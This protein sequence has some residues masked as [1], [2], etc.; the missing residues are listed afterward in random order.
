[1]RPPG[2]EPMSLDFGGAVSDDEDDDEGG[3]H[4]RSAG[5][6]SKY[7][8]DG[9]GGSAGFALR[10]AGDAAGSRSSTPTASPPLRAPSSPDSHRPIA[11]FD[12]A[13]ESLGLL[14]RGSFS[15]VFRARSRRS[16]R[17]Y[18]VKRS[19][20]HV[21]SAAMRDRLAREVALAHHAGPHPAVL[22]Y[23]DAWQ[24]GGH[25][26]IRT[27]CC[28]NGTLASAAARA[29]RGVLPGAQCTSDSPTGPGPAG[30]PGA[31]CSASSASSSGAAAGAPPMLRRVDSAF[32]THVPRAVLPEAALWAVAAR[33]AGGLAHLHR[34][35]VIHGDVKTAN[36]LLAGD[37]GVLLADLGTASHVDP[38]TGAAPPA[39]AE[40]GDSRYLAPEMLA[41][42]RGPTPAADVFSMG[43][44][45][46]ELC[47]ALLPPANGDGWRA[48]RAGALPPIM[49]AVRP[50]RSEALVAL[51]AA[52][53]RPD[54]ADRPTAADVA[55]M[56]QCAAALAA[57]PQLCLCAPAAAVTAPGAVVAAKSI[58]GAVLAAGAGA[59]GGTLGRAPS[60]RPGMGAGL[61]AAHSAASSDGVPS[62]GPGSVG[63][64]R[65]AAPPSSKLKRS[66]S[67]LR[68][69]RADDDGAM[70]PRALGFAGGASGADSDDEESSSLDVSSQAGAFAMTVGLATSSSS[71]P[72]TQRPRLTAAGDHGLCVH[73]PAMAAG[74]PPGSPPLVTP[75]DAVGSSWVMGQNR[76]LPPSAAPLAQAPQ[77]PAGRPAADAASRG[78]RHVVSRR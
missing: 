59:A 12:A 25:L 49:R 40:D 34:A 2:F 74:S 68:R 20:R 41:T 4:E 10:R 5:A 55:G 62:A 58:S 57:P 43:V 8:N 18:A 29:A 33:M 61:S 70:A 26:L 69:S 21:T 71:G 67:D 30:F 78:A 24:E 7:S 11:G 38:A 42:S 27:Q 22:R 75:V 44:V 9:E 52:L 72:A 63:S 19:L 73:V 66:R 48:L 51:I 17:L 13:F 56:S 39:E 16:R 6:D 53:L 23:H 14:G 64:A 46:F 45:L 32:H 1:M 60:W 54:P 15:V 35:G 50:H 65:R 36:V 47:W 31:T 76:V 77:R 37:G 28:E 3:W